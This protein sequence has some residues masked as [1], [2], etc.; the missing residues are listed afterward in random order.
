MLH[1]TFLGPRILESLCT[2]GAYALG[3]SPEV[4]ITSTVS[5]NSCRHEQYRINKAAAR[6][7]VRSDHSELYSSCEDITKQLSG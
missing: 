4:V 6:D 2:S 5:I 1:V 7:V 3:F